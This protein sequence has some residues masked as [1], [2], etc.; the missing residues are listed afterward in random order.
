MAVAQLDNKTRAAAID[1]PESDGKPMTETD[2]PREQM[3]D[4]LTAIS[5]LIHSATIS[6]RRYAAIAWLATNIFGWKA[7]ARA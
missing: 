1:Y 7:M 3:T 5:S 2:I 4:L 6:P